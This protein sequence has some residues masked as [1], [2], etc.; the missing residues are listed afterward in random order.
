MELPR[1]S[2]FTLIERPYGR[3]VH[4]T[5]HDTPAQFEQIFKYL[6]RTGHVIPP[7]LTALREA[8][9]RFPDG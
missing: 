7:A 1:M 4:T 9:V 2:S 5:P 8:N 3:E 6:E